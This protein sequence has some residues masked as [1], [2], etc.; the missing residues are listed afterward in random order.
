MNDDYPIGT[1]VVINR[2]NVYIVHN[3][4]RSPFVKVWSIGSL[5][6]TSV[7]DLVARAFIQSF[8][9]P[10]KTEN[11]RKWAK[12]FKQEGVF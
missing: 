7:C 6:R 8:E 2:G 9:K 11:I 3:D 1:N 4:G 5:H 10:N 12:A